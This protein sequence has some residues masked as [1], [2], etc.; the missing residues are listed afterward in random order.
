[1]M[2]NYVWDSQ[3][4]DVMNNLIQTQVFGKNNSETIQTIRC[5]TIEEFNMD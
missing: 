1:M 3:H 2:I 5:D 4:L